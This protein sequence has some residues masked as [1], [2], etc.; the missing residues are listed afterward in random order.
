MKM[1]QLIRYSTE[2]SKVMLH[3]INGILLATKL[4]PNQK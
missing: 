1:G 4:T 2:H 3:Y